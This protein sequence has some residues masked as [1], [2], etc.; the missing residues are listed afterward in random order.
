MGL[1][2][3]YFEPVKVKDIILFLR[4][5][6]TQDVGE[7]GT[8]SSFDAYAETILFRN[9]LFPT[10]LLQL[11]HRTL[12][13]T[14]GCRSGFF[15]YCFHKCMINEFEWPKIRAINATEGSKFNWLTTFA[16]LLLKNSLFALAWHSFSNF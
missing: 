3:N 15:K 12:R 14:N 1:V 13:Q 8:A 5:I 9:I 10:N 11:F 16:A 6:K 2:H 7:A 4:H